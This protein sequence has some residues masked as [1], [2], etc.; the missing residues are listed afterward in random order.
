MLA[1]VKREAAVRGLDRQ[2]AVRKIIEDPIF[3]DPDN[4]LTH[5]GRVFYYRT[6]N[7]CHYALIAYENFYDSGQRLVALLE[8]QPQFLKDNLSDYIAALSNFILSCGLLKKYP[9]VRE[10]LDKLWKLKPIT[11]D[12]GLK[13]RRQYF[14][15][16]FVLCI[17][18][19]D[20]EEGKQEMERFLSLNKDHLIQEHETAS[21]YF[22]YFSIC[23]GCGAFDE[24]LDWLNL[25][26][27]QP[28]NT[29]REDL[30]SLARILELMLHFEMRNYTLC[31]SLLRSAT[32]F[33]S[34]KKRLYG[35]ELVFIKGISETL[36]TV[37]KDGY[38]NKAFIE[39]KKDFSEIVQQPEA[40][41][42][43]QTFDLAAWL[44]SKI[45]EKPFA[46][47]VKEKVVTNL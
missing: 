28:K 14:T 2:Q 23:F 33:I 32:R 27:S 31:D 6:L 11:K 21:F 18:T 12:D 30:Q 13:I 36:K 9:E 24:A 43:L 5:T 47:V 3:S 40:Q 35:L 15:T 26:L 38:S 42:L 25:W 41:V 1:V 46:E 37:H 16:K 44:D 29:D 45:S 10:S 22:Q 7:L 34:K 8:S 17:F 39:M 20:F 4:A 19:G